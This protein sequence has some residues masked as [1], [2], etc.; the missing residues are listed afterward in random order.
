VRGYDKV[1][2]YDPIERLKRLEGRGSG[3]AAAAGA[4]GAAAA[5]TGSGAAGKQQSPF[6]D[7][8]S[9]YRSLEAE[10]EEITRGV[11]LGSFENKPVP[12]P[13]DDEW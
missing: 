12:R 6:S 9:G 2:E 5:G 3:A 13:A 7:G 10:L 4:A 11:D 1:E 8:A